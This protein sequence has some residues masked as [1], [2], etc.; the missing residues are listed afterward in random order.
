M[1]PNLVDGSRRSQAL[2]CGEIRGC[3]GDEQRPR[4]LR[5]ERFGAALVADPLLDGDAQQRRLAAGRVPDV[6]KP[7]L[8]RAG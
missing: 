1:A 5:A 4:R 3:P 2:G 6:W 8:V 7:Y